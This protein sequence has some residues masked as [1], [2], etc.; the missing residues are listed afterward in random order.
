LQP[1]YFPWVKA[2][3]A[4]VERFLQTPLG[5]HFASFENFAYLGQGASEAVVGIGL[6]VF[7]LTLIS[8][9]A[10]HHYRRTA[11]VARS[12][13]FDRQLW[14]LHTAPWALL[15]L[16]MAK[17]GTMEP[18]RQIAAYY[19]FL[20]PLFLARPGHVRLVR[21]RWWQW[22]GLLVMLF[23]AGLLVVS[24]SRPLFPAETTIAPLKEKY[25]RWK[26]LS[27]AW[28][29]YACRF[30][31]ETQRK[32]FKDGLL[33]DE[34]VVGYATIRGSQEAGLWLPFGRRRV[35]RVIPG[36]TPQQLQQAGI[37]YVVL[38]NDWP[39]RL[40]GTIE[41]WAKRY[42]GVLVDQLDVETTP[43]NTGSIYLVRLGA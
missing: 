38:D 27:K 30:S 37:H 22:L 25:P 19:V 9:W 13:K 33:R 32:G 10:A 4:A 39:R 14:L 29:S 41:Q 23:T 7:V 28:D 36:D 15:L 1:P 24:R 11:G 21:Q 20:F 26:F 42:H 17:V 2:W 35:V 43:G 12:V 5:A 34:S 3:N 6:G 31:V 40:G 8:I 16:F 18:A